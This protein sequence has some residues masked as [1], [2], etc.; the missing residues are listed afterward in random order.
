MRWGFMPG[1]RQHQGD[2][3][4]LA[5]SAQQECWVV[6]T[7]SWLSW[8]A[9]LCPVVPGMPPPQR[10]ARSRYGWVTACT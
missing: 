9:H 7:R 1:Q 4:S 6:M 3:H 5:F 2:G 8:T 10:G